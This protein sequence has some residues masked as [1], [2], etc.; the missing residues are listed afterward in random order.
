[1][2][3][4]FPRVTR[5]LKIKCVIQFIHSRYVRISTISKNLN[6]SER[7]FESLVLPFSIP[8]TTKADLVPKIEKKRTF[9]ILKVNDITT[10]THKT[11]EGTEGT[12]KTNKNDERINTI[13]LAISGGIK[14][15][16]TGGAATMRGF[17]QQTITINGEKRP[18]MEA[19]DYISGLSGGVV[20]TLLYPYAQ[21]VTTEE[22]L[23][24]DYRLDDPSQITP[25]ALD[26]KTSK[27]TL[28][29]NAVE[30]ATFK[31][32]PMIF[33]GLFCCKLHSIF[34]LVQWFATL[35]PF[36]IKRDQKIS[37]DPHPT[38]KNT[39]GPRPGIKAIPL[40]NFMAMGKADG[41]AQDTIEGY[42]KLVTKLK[43]KYGKPNYTSL[44]L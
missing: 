28:F 11:M 32:L 39:I 27:P 43:E 36:G 15:A 30:S 29:D 1:M 3:S 40:V 25:Q 12:A 38:A 33:Y 22:L 14:V 8:T 17:Q 21:N 42:F 7:I 26:R 9:P 37:P 4:T 35:D 19:F 20:P 18:A 41:V 16:A 10:H 31:S 5:H 34:A 13:G 23:D 2:D 44:D 24:S 6:L